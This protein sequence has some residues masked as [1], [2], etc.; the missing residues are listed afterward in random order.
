MQHCDAN[1]TPSSQTQ[2]VGLMGDQLAIAKEE[3]RVNTAGAGRHKC[4]SCVHAPFEGC[5]KGN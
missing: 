2:V 1:E 5:W 3:S 4:F